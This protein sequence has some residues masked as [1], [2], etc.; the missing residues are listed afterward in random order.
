[1]KKAARPILVLCFLIATGIIALLVYRPETLFRPRQGQVQRQTK[2]IVPQTVSAGTGDEE[3]ALRERMAYEDTMNAKIALDE[4][5]ILVSVLTANFDEEPQDEQIIAYRKL[6][7]RAAPLLSENPIWLAYIDN[8]NQSRSWERVWD[9][10]T[11]VTRPGTV[12]LY[13]KDLVGDRRVCVILTGM[14]SENEHIMVIFRK[15]GEGGED[16]GVKHFEKIADI[17]IDGSITIQE[18]ERTQAYQL[19]L[20]KG[21][22]FTIAAYGRD[23]ESNN[24]LDQIETIYSFNENLGRYQ[25][26]AFTRIP[27]SRIEQQRVRELLTGSSRDF[28]TFISGLWYY[29]SPQGTL[30]NRQYIYFDPPNRELIFY[31]NETQQVFAWGS[32]SATRYGLYI[33]SNNI[34]VTT[35]RRSID[36]ELESLNSIRVKVFEDVRL[37]IGVNDSWDGS[38][39]KAENSRESAGR[40]TSEGNPGGNT[41]NPGAAPPAYLNAAY[42]GSV[43]KLT[44]YK[45]GAYELHSDNSVRRGNYAFFT[46]DGTAL[47]EL[48]PG[49]ITEASR[50]TYLVEMPAETPA[51]TPWNA[52]TLARVRLSTRGFQDMHEAAIVLSL[53]EM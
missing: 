13:T 5:E 43:G 14:N 10:A 45:N 18:T 12:S 8:E 24:I 36:I 28:E 34:S 22:S 21:H 35:L 48:R 11:A 47:L 15:T 19:G 20:T 29:V 16:P 26:S 4:G 49:G 1:M 31:G 51:G 23:S 41:K 7:D 42:E 9:T 2:L 40:V 6:Q 30:D 33:S 38:Y 32:S 17:R 3:T 27:G 25:Q 39:R 53:I 44:F 50:E 37:K 46:L 52:L